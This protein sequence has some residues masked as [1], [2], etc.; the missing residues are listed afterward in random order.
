[1]GEETRRSAKDA[2]LKSFEGRDAAI[3]NLRTF[4]VVLVVFLHAAIGY[5]SFSEYDPK[6][7]IDATA[8][9]VDSS[10]WSA[11]DLPVV[12]IDTFSMPLLFLI[13]GLFIFSGLDRKGSGG[14]FLSRLKRLGIPF[15]AAAFLI[16]PLAFWPSYLMATP[17]SPTPYWIRFFTTDG[18]LIG[19]PWFL[20]LL[21]AFDGVAALIH[22]AAPAAL[23]KL[24]RAPKVW[25]ILLVMI[26]AYAPVRLVID[27]YFWITRL[28]PLDVQASR[29]LLYLGSFLL[30]MALGTGQTWRRAGWP[31]H[32][33]VWFLVALLSFPVYLFSSQAGDAIMARTINGLAFSVCC[34]GACLGFIGLFRQITPKRNPI[35]DSLNANAFGVY[36]FH[37]P[38]VH[39]LQFALVPVGLPAPVKFGAAFLGG[40][41]LSWG[42]SALAR[43]I[44]VVRGI[45]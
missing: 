16:S 2:M 4:V 31:K 19:A 43:K 33:G 41:L 32:W 35:I 38:I 29:I 23:E 17:D 14:F 39:W 45:I 7:Y 1:M 36:L 24:R 42:T 13:S 25:T 30:G 3:D 20:W 6:H 28:G 21:L 37:Y 44:A 5:T 26:A 10:R 22:R 18:W 34:A 15:L 12:F 8:P 11:L 27:P 9:V 40:L